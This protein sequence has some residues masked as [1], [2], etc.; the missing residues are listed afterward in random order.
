MKPNFLFIGPDKTGSSWLYSVLAQHPQCFVPPAKDIYFFD[1]YYHRG[2][3]WYEKFFD[4]APFGARAV[5]ELSH[6]Y[7]LSSEVAARVAKDLPGV[8]LLTIVRNPVQRTFSNYLYLVRSGL[9][10]APFA[11]ALREFPSLI[12]NSLY[13][14]HLEAY[15]A[16][17]PESQ[18]KI[19][20]FD[21]LEA[22]PRWF[23]WQVFEFLGLEFLETIRYEERVLPASRP[24]SALI[25]RLLKSGADFARDLRLTNTVGVVKRSAF[26]RLMYSPY[27][28]SER[29][30]LSNADRAALWQRFADDVCLL[31]ARTGRDLAAWRP[32]P[33]A[34]V[35]L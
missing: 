8:R 14:R 28:M 34:S 6:D 13:G 30:R 19:L 21:D 26:A 1:R 23:A 31:E 25:A 2:F 3:T 10:R 4:C 29:P 12:D 33:A 20:F 15:W 27:P 32:A 22:D 9:T 24:R 5:G 35:Q 11:D 16:L 7:I 18:L 17:F